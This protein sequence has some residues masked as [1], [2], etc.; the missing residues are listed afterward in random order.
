V[1]IAPILK[2][3][4]HRLVR[5]NRESFSITQSASQHTQHHVDHGRSEERT[6]RVIE[7]L[8]FFDDYKEWPGLKTLVEVHAQRTDK[9]TGKSESSC[10]YFMISR[11]DSAKNFNQNICSHWAVENKLYWVLDVTFNEGQSRK[12]KGKSAENFGIITKIAINLLNQNPDKLS[13]PNKRIQAMLSD[14]YREKLLQL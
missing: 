11:K 13:K 5:A 9:Q 4:L 1:V 12:R 6:C 10:R 14:Q 7:D 2:L 8:T 3:Q